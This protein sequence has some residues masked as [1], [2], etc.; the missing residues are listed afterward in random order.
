[1]NLLPFPEGRNGLYENP[2]PSERSSSS[3]VIGEAE[4]D[5]AFFITTRK[6]TA[7]LNK[8]TRRKIQ[9]KIQNNF[10]IFLISWS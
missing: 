3:T 2:E 7:N 8:N 1:M 5:D 4:N 9:D 10:H 6:A